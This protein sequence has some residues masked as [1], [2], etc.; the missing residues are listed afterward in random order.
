MSSSRACRSLADARSHPKRRSIGCGL[1]DALPL[2]GCCILGGCSELDGKA[3]FPDD[4]AF[5]LLEAPVRDPSVN[6]IPL[7]VYELPRRSGDAQTYRLGHPLAEAVVH[8]AKVRSIVP[9]EIEFSYEDHQGKVSILEPL[10]GS[11]G[12]LSVSLFTVESLEQAEDHLLFAGVTDGGHVLDEDA[13][14]RLLSLP[15]RVV[16]EGVS[17]D[18]THLRQI[19]GER[20][21]VI[22]RGITERNARFFEAEADKLEGWADDLKLGLER[23]IK[24]IDGQVKEARRAAM[25]V[26]TL[27]EKLAGQKRIKGLEAQRNEKRR[28]LFDAQDQVDRQRDALIDNIEGKLERQRSVSVLFTASWRLV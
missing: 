12:T 26:L 19:A 14:R 21:A 9:A 20:Q 17:L 16:R 28:S 5:R 3:R 25:V 1:V 22:Q 13:A 11:S 4:G 7:G 2:C 27:E 18:E 23:E 24:E 10:R 8:R 15:G 6:T